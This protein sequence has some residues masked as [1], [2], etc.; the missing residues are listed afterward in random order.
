MSATTSRIGVDVGKAEVW[1]SINGEPA[2]CC[3]NTPAAIERWIRG[4]TEPADFAMEATSDYHLVTALEAIRQGHR[5]YLINGYRLNRYRESIGG[6]A[7]TDAGD[8]RLLVRYL[9]RE[10]DDLRPWTPPPE[11]YQTLQKLLRRRATLVRARV[12]LQQ[13]LRG[14]P[15]LQTG[16]KS[17]LRQIQKIDD[18]LQRHLHKAVDRAGWSEDSRRCKQMEGVGPITAA[19]LTMAFHRGHFRSSDAFIA[20]LG[21]D[22]RVRDSGQKRGRR[23]LTKQGDPEVRRLLYLAAMQAKS[24]PAWQDYYQRC[25]DR[26]LATTQALN[27]LARK[28]ARVAFALMKKQSD[29][30]PKVPC[31]QT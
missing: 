24:K 4:L 14:V 15:E 17:L 21:L 6:R 12:M 2:Q 29:Y 27:A 23:R 9:E 31:G 7:K 13:S 10:Q 19:A 8:A 25:L 11:G 20:F 26:G 30:Q 3:K 22:V 16:L 18:E 28:L 5:V 1:F